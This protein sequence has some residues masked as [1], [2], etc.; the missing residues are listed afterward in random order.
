MAKVTELIQ[1]WRNKM[2]VLD[3]LY[4]AESH[5]WLKIEGATGR[6]GIT[7]FAQ[8]SLGDVV[9][10][11]MPEEG[12]QFAAGDVFGAIESSKAASDLNM[13]V[14]GTVT[15]INTAVEDDPSLVNSDAYANWLIEIEIGDAGE[16]SSLMNA[17]AYKE[18]AEASEE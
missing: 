3:G 8:H 7:D 15:K 16:A 5:E 9:F 18:F 1:K 12:E 6:I 4:Y 14:A 11:E 2:N 17:A 13:P 10:V